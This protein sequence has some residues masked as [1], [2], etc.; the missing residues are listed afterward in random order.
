MSAL[1]FASINPKPPQD[2]PEQLH[3]INPQVQ[4]MLVMLGMLPALV[5]GLSQGGFRSSGGWQEHLSR[6]QH[7]VSRKQL[8]FGKHWDQEGQ[9]GSLCLYIL[10]TTNIP[11][12]NGPFFA[13][14]GWPHIMNHQARECISPMIAFR[15]PSAHNELSGRESMIAVRLAF[16]T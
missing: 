13:R 3:P 1:R 15:W 12:G 4:V 2:S 8:L 16:S 14:S 6:W 10:S 9:P 11:K 5:A 7:V